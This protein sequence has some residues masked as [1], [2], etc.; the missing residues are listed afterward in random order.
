MR[1]VRLISEID[2]TD[3][4]SSTRH[5]ENCATLGNGKFDIF[6]PRVPLLTKGEIKIHMSSMSGHPK[7]PLDYISPYFVCIEIRIANLSFS[8]K[9]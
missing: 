3:A 6:G 4:T 8:K 1:T 5:K 7:W 2:A 9:N